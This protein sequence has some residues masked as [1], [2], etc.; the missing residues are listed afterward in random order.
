MIVRVT[1]TFDV[2]IEDDEELRRQAYEG[3]TDPIECAAFDLK[4]NPEMVFLESD[5]DVVR[6]EIPDV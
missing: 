4:V 2:P 6:M 3:I 5:Y 1:L